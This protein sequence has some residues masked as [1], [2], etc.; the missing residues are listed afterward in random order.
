LDFKTQGL[1]PEYT[2]TNFRR[3]FVFLKDPGAPLVW[4][5]NPPAGNAHGFI[6]VD[7]SSYPAPAVIR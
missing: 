4:I 1:S 3:R 5:N 2:V 7:G 6:V